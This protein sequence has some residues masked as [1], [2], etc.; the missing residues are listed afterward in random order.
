MTEERS[1]PPTAVSRRA[2]LRTSAAGAGALLAGAAPSGAFAAGS[3]SVKVGLIGCGSRGNG[4]ARNCLEAAR[5]VGHKVELW[6][7]GDLYEDAARRTFNALRSWT[8]K[9][10]PDTFAVTPERVFTGFGNYRQVFE[11]GV[12]MVILATPPGFRPIQFA[13]AVAADKHVFMEKPVCV[14]PWGYKT[15]CAAADTARE[16]KLTVIAGTQRRHRFARR[17][18]LR[19]IRDGAVGDLVAGQCYWIGGPVTHDRGRRAGQTDIDWQ[20]R[21]WYAWCWTCGDHVVEQHVHNI[22]MICWAFGTH[23][24]SA[25]AV[26]GRQSRPE[27]GNIYDHF[28]VEFEFPGGARVA[29]Y[30]S[31]FQGSSGRVGERVVGTKGTSHLRGRIEG[32]NAWQYNGEDR[33]PY[34]QE[35]VDALGSLLGTGD[36]WNEG[37]QVA[38]SSMAAVLGRMSAYTGAQVSWDWA[39]K[40][41][42]LRLGKP[43]WDWHSF[44]SYDPPPVPAPGKTRLV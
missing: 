29:S 25:K 27:P 35:H 15:I 38:E 44:G 16:K 43:G 36:Y 9:H 34:V 7:L 39:V 2:F 41:S 14:D 18:T 8:R 26:G 12:D 1:R 24:G 11:S 20:I 3:D 17:E 40:E 22:D 19:R 6:A 13:A 42:K 4:A 10:A 21:N 32:E 37:R 23:P 5:I 28:A 33:H 30:A 31:H